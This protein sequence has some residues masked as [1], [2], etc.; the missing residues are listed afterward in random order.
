MLECIFRHCEIEIVRLDHYFDLFDHPGVDP[1]PFL[2]VVAFP[3]AFCFGPLLYDFPFVLAAGCVLVSD[4]V[5]FLYV[6]CC[7]LF[8]CHYHFAIPFDLWLF[9]PDRAGP[10]IKLKLSFSFFYNDFSI[11]LLLY[12]F[13]CMCNIHLIRP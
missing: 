5:A 6:Q 1:C 9:G 7:D 3:A 8:M 4:P 11:N 12:P 10:V 2:R 13:W